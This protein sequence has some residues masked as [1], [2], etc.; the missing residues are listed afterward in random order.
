MPSAVDPQRLL[1]VAAG[2]GALR[3]RAADGADLALG[4][5]VVAGAAPLQRSLDTALEQVADTLRALDA[6]A[7][8]L[9]ARLREVALSAAASE[10]RVTQRTRDV[11]PVGRGPR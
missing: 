1:E 5:V 6:G 7:G 4:H 2:L 3:R 8:D 9:S 11:R 10:D